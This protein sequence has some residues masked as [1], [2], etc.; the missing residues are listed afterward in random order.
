MGTVLV[1]DDEKQILDM[2]KIALTMK[3]H[4]VEVAGNGNEGIN[5]F[6][7]SS[8]DVVITDICMP[9]LDGVGV[10]HHIRESNKKAT[11]IVGISG[12]PWNIEGVDF[13]VILQ[14]PFSIKTLL[15][16]VST[17]NEKQQHL[18]AGHIR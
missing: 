16:H 17:L 4:K 18:P 3:G 13:D 15:D 14:K 2:L 8:Y 6:D 9:G 1:I 12:T 10:V 11:P 7:Q 5:K